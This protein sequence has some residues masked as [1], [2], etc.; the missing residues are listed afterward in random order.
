MAAGRGSCRFSVLLR[1]RKDE[2]PALQPQRAFERNDGAVVRIPVESLKFRDVLLV[3]TRPQREF[4]LRPSLAASGLSEGAM[5]NSH[6]GQ[7]KRLWR[8]VCQRKSYHGR[9]KSGCL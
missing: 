6:H 4:A 7:I 9:R 1:H 5:S 3:H 2:R 8:P